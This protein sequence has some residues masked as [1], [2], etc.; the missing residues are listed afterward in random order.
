M[1]TYVTSIGLDVHARSIKG[2]AF[3]PYTGEMVIKSFGYSPTEVAEWILTFESPKAVYETGVTGFHLARS[4]KSL[5]VDCVVGAISKMQKPSADKHRKTD[6]RDAEFLARLLA[7]HN[8]VAVMVPDEGCEA[9]RDI[10]RALA[11]ARDDLVAA[12]QRLTKFLLRHGR[13]FDEK[14]AR[15]QRITNWTHAHWKWIYAQQF[16]ES[17]AQETLFYYIEQVKQLE[18][19]K[20]KLEKLIA[21]HAK[22]QRWKERVD[23]I[24][25]IK[26]IETVTAFALVAEVQVFSRFESASSFAAWLGLVPSEHS[27]G[28]TIGKG[29]IT[30]AGNAHGRK[31]LVEAAWHFI[32]ASPKSKNLDFDQKVSARLRNHTNKSNKRLISRCAYLHERGKKPVVANCAIA[33]ELACWIWAVGCMVEGTL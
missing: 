12:K 17:A 32:N 5:G 14:N 7:T 26:G 20:T 28:E 21:T 15:G 2:A 3:N 11:D 13:L 9:A 6:K 4:L 8:V 22:E 16:S 1:D 31:L 33:R 23:A 10:T 25:C 29:G 27:S 30:K 24:R 19:A 18:I